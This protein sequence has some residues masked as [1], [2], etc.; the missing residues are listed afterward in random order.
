MTIQSTTSQSAVIGQRNTRLLLWIV[1]SG[2]IILG[3]IAVSIIGAVVYTAVAFN[4]VPEVLVNWGGL[5][6][7]FFLGNFF[8]LLRTAVGLSGVPDEKPATH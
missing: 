1:G 4:R 8:N 6:I 3:I 7:G 2:S 5:I